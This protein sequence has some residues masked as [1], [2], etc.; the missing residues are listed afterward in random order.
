ML[1]FI[2]SQAERSTAELLPWD[3]EVVPGVVMNKDDSL[4]SLFRFHG[5]DIEGKGWDEISYNA[6][7]WV[8][9][10]QLMPGRSWIY[11]GFQRRRYLDR[12][13]S[14]GFAD[15]LSRQIDD[16]WARHV[17]SG[18]HFVNE[19]IVGFGLPSACSNS[20]LDS[21]K[22]RLGEGATLAQAIKFSIANA[23]RPDR[24]AQLRLQRLVQDAHKLSTL[25]QGALGSITSL[26]ARQL[27]AE[28]LNAVLHNSISLATPMARV[29]EPD[30][31][32]ALASDTL[33]PVGNA[34]W[35][36]DGPTRTVYAA[37][38]TLRNFGSGKQT[39]VGMLEVIMALPIEFNYAQTFRFVSR[40]GARD[41]IKSTRN[42]N[43]TR[44]KNA[45]RAAW[46]KAT[47]NHDNSNV[48]PGRLLN[49]QET[50]DAEAA[51]TNDDV[52]FG[53]AN[54]S[55]VVLGESIADCERAVRIMTETINSRGVMVTREYVGSLSAFRGTL[56]GAQKDIAIWKWGQFGNYV[57]MAPIRTEDCG[58][59]TTP[60]WSE[61]MQKSVPALCAMP[62]NRGTVYRYSQLVGQTGH[63][64]VLGP[65]GGGKT[66]L[67][68]FLAS[69]GK[70]VDWDIVRIDKDFSTRITTLT[71]GGDYCD[72]TSGAVEFNPLSMAHD[73][74]HHAFLQRF[75]KSLVVAHGYKWTA[76][77]SAV[78][79]TAVKILSELDP[80]HHHLEGLFPYVGDVEIQQA[81]EPWLPGNA[82]GRFFGSRKD[83]LQL[84][85]HFGIDL[86][87]ILE[88]PIVS[89]R[90][91]DVLF[92]RI[93]DKLERQ[94]QP[95][96]MFIDVQE[97]R[98][99]L[100]D[101]YF[102]EVFIDLLVTIRK[103]MG[104]LSFSTQSL[105]H[106]KDPAIWQSIGDN[107]PTRWFTPN[108]QAKTDEWREA[109][110]AALGLSD[111]QLETIALSRPA[112]DYVLVRPEA[113]KT[114]D[115]ALPA[116]V[117]ATLRGDKLALDTFDK[118]Y[119]AH[120]PA[121]AKANQDWAFDY[122]EDVMSR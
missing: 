113:T 5:L 103:K 102:R 66:V 19:H 116:S 51:L 17:A 88:D 69:Q 120:D 55:I 81:M 14:D 53:Y 16:W 56:P 114:I 46:D 8:R 117:V 74:R 67:T 28:E 57:S 65:T 79:N 11:L 32:D 76:R 18:N 62:T 48:D 47:N 20:V 71:H 68:N 122:I 23:A 89:T 6:D 95:R 38:L 85:N 37:T 22:Y 42:Y 78:L 106:L 100:Q 25:A 96:P 118:H 107:V 50:L 105:Q 45:V 24:F 12:L 9:Q 43:E 91:L 29:A 110:K 61:Q 27:E 90:V 49:I 83:T 99:F 60:W 77:S 98:Y 101:P 104:L 34:M 93:K 111:A 30:S 87:K 59:A 108:V 58:Q 80:S 115:L 64:F 112:R 44:K 33:T 10:S 26:R 52:A 15:E 31:L 7:Q 1:G 121:A 82:L 73:R 4:F 21:V 3:R 36:W 109:Y 35:R 2:K 40:S 119:P 13:P 41:Q 97:I 94:S 63:M 54:T 70:R 75:C 92:Y 86:G 72:M 39:D 84:T